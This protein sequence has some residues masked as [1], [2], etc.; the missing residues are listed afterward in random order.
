MFTDSLEMKLKLTVGSTVF[1]IPGG[2]IKA[3]ELNLQPYG[4]TSM[5]SFW[6]SDEESEDELFPLFIKQD[7]IRVHLTVS[8]LKAS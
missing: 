5:L 1:N 2:N 3:L 8:S 6:V 4:F 7:L